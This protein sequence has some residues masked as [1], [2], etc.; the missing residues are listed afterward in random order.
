MIKCHTGFYGNYSCITCGVHVEWTLL[1]YYIVSPLIYHLVWLGLSNVL[2][3]IC[4]Q[5]LYNLGARKIALAALGPIGCIPYQLT[6]RLRRNGQCDPKVNG[7]AQQFNSGVLGMVNSLNA[8]LPGAKFIIL[9]AY[10]GVTDMIANP[11][12]H[13]KSQ[14]SSSKLT[15]ASLWLPNWQYLGG[16]FNLGLK[17]LPQTT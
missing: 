10:K 14:S 7:E 5:T 13:G 2:F 12:A 17:K 4:V 3:L 8:N 6:L 11:A 15:C 9:D 16:D 1:S